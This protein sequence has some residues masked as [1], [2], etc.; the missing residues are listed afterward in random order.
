MDKKIYVS[1]SDFPSLER[2]RKEENSIENKQIFLFDSFSIGWTMDTR[3]I[4]A[5]P[6]K[7]GLPV[8]YILW[9]QTKTGEHS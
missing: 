1:L 9:S 8:G 4:P 5:R 6:S 3:S 2:S 7:A